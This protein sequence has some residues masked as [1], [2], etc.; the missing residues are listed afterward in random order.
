S[1]RM[2]L[3][4]I[5][6]ASSSG[7]PIL[8]YR[9]GPRRQSRRSKPATTTGFS[10]A[11]GSRRASGARHRAG[12]AGMGAPAST[13]WGFETV[14]DRGTIPGSRRALG[15]RGVRLA[16]GA[17]GVAMRGSSYL[18]A[19]QRMIRDQGLHAPAS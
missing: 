18:T 6:L 2:G 3:S 15:A 17:G 4:F 7:T 19:G 13:R 8:D 1:I 16:N 9:R 12:E 14:V 11:A 10:R 5:A